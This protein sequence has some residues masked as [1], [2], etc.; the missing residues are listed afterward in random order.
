MAPRGRVLVQGR[1]TGMRARRPFGDTP[2]L[3][4]AVIEA[5]LRRA[6]P[7]ARELLQ[8]LERQAR[9]AWSTLRLD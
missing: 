2:V 4:P 7:G 6:A 1:G 9:R 3:T 5:A 8:T